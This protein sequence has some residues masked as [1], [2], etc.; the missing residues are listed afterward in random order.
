MLE[1]TSSNLCL[2]QSFHPAVFFRRLEVLIGEMRHSL[3]IKMVGNKFLLFSFAQFYLQTLIVL[4]LLF[5]VFLCTT[6]MNK[7][8]TFIYE[9]LH[10][11]SPSLLPSMHLFCSSSKLA[12]ISISVFTD[13]Y[14]RKVNVDTKS[15]C[16]NFA[17]VGVKILDCLLGFFCFFF[18]LPTLC[19]QSGCLCIMFIPE[20]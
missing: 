20:T 5:I 16:W 18:L 17:G 13:I 7:H 1:G 3:S 15:V 19:S 4:Q 8:K 9:V 11:L 2:R 10:N 6:L 12:A 14:P